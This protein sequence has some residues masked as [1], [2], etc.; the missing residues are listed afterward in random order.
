MS[1]DV[2]KPKMLVAILF[3]IAGICS[4]L[5]SFLTIYRAASYPAA[6]VVFQLFTTGLLICCAIMQWATYTKQYVNY[7]I[8]EAIG[9]QDKEL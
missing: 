5:S 9:S 7:R 3:T 4:L 8:D 2:G 6:F 1:K